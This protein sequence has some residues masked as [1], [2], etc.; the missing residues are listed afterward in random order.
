MAAVMAEHK[1]ELTLEDLDIDIEE[2]LR[3]VE[4]ADTK[5]KLRKDN[6]WVRDIIRI[7]WGTETWMFMHTLTRRLWDLRNSSGLPMPDEFEK[8]VQSAINQ[9]TSQSKVWVKNGRK[10][11]DDLFHSP[12]G[13]FSGTWAVHRARAIAWLKARSLPDV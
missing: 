8:T 4:A 1:G 11:A 5:H 6:P 2:L 13:K 12:K 10:E 9:H 7:L 3:L